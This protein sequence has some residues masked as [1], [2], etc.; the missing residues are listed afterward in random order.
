MASRLRIQHCSIRSLRS[1]HGVHGERAYSSQLPTPRVRR[2][3]DPNYDPYANS[4][5]GPESQNK[6]LAE[7]SGSAPWKARLMYGYMKLFRMDI[8]ENQA[9]PVAGGIYMEQCK[10]QAYHPPGA[11]LYSPLAEFYYVDLDLTPT[12]AQWFSIASLHAWMLLVRMRALPPKYADVYEQA[13]ID[14]I[15]LDM[16]KRIVAEY[17]VR[18]GRLINNSL[19]EFNVQLRGAVFAYDEA[20]LVSD[21]VLAAAI[22]RNVFNGRQNI[23]L[24]HLASLVR[25]VRT[26]LYVLDK[27]SDFDFAV[28]RFA[29]LP[30][31]IEYNPET[32]FKYQPPPLPSKQI[33]PGY[34]SRF[35]RTN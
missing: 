6:S 1:V 2:V 3:L 16:E 27:M 29:F 34:E 17:N 7:L 18:S 4:R 8:E 12:L 15:F 26:H 14:G 33:F 32:V 9:A 13:L 35:S 30:P 28:G 25:H 20:I 22:W 21:A 19:K 23:N 10:I 5:F 31:N 11:K 24:D